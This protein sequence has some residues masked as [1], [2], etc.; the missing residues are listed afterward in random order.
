M[1][2][3]VNKDKLVEEMITNLEGVIAEFA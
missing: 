1:R 3:R 2:L